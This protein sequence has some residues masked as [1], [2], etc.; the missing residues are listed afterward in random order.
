MFKE[1]AFMQA[2]NAM[3]PSQLISPSLIA[4]T[5]SQLNE[6]AEIAAHTNGTLIDT[7]QRLFGPWPV[8]GEKGQFREATSGLAADLADVIAR[9]RST[10]IDA[11]DNALSLSSAL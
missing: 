1:A 9:V 5:I 8:A 6:I 3:E 2:H 11:R 4:S 7:R 10:V